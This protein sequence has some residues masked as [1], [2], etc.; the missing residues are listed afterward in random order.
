MNQYKARA[1]KG[2]KRIL[3]I[4]FLIMLFFIIWYIIVNFSPGEI[5]PGI[6][7]HDPPDQG[8]V[9]IDITFRKGEYTIIPLASFEMKGKVLAK[10][11]YRFGRE[12]EI[13]P[14]DLAMGWGRMSD[15]GILQKIKIRQSNRWYYWR[16]K[17][18]PIPRREIETSSANMHIIPA[19]NKIKK[20]VGETSKWDLIRLKGYL[21]KVI[22]DDNWIWKSSLTRKDTGNHSCEVIWV[23]E[24]YVIN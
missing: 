7:V 20:M 17:E 18:W 14:Y 21:V 24:F 16:V 8:K 15:E 11:R 13:S 22:A 19:N 6:Q 2:Q 12:S 3:F 9:S 10:K 1:T 23:E 4:L 5:Q